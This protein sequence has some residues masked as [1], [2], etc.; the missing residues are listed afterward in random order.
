MQL[1]QALDAI[2]HFSPENF[3]SLSSLLSPEMI[4]HIPANPDTGTGLI[5][6]PVFLAFL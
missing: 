4:V 3:S 1:S 2:H 5:R 6:T